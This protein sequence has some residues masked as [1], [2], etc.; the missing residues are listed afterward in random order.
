MPFKTAVQA[1]WNAVRSWRPDREK[2]WHYVFMLFSWACFIFACWRTWQV[3]YGRMYYLLDSDMSSELVLSHLLRQE[4][5]IV[6]QDWF[7]STELRVFNIHWAFT[8]LFFLFDNWLKVRQIGTFIVLA[9]MVLSCL[10]FCW[11]AGIRQ[12]FPLIAAVMMTPVSDAYFRILLLTI[13]Y[14]PYITATFFTMGLLFRYMKTPRRRTRVIQLM[15][16]TAFA[17]LLGTNGLRQLLILYLPLFLGALLLAV[18]RSPARQGDTLPE[19]D[20]A[21]GRMLFGSTAALLG[22]GIGWQINAKVLRHIYH[23]TSQEGVQFKAFEGTRLERLLTG[24]LE[25]VVQQCGTTRQTFYRNF[26]DKYD[27]VNWYFDRILL[28]SFE[29]MGEGSTIPEGLINKFRYIEQEKIFFKAA[30]KNNDQNNLRDH[31]FE[32]ILAFYTERI[33][34][35]THAAVPKHLRLLLEMYCHASIYM[36]VQWVLGQIPSTPEEMAGLLVD[37]MPPQLE[38]TFRELNL[39]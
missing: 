4:H 23:Y 14:P 11:Q 20:L 38:Q 16:I 6:T 36:T 5:K 8:P 31:D 17:V 18:L 1:H 34:S 30:F 25:K 15:I 12:L 7:Y 35:R 26:K 32:L 9:L 22:A 28:E 27:L 19:L 21:T 33:E 2:R 24:W 39:L 13:S 3:V 10:Y 29:H 37:A